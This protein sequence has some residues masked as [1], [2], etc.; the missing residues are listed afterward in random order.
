[1]APNCISV[2]VVEGNR[3][4]R[5]TLGE[6]LNSQSDM[7]CGRAL[8]NCERALEAIDAGEVPD[9]VL[10]DLGL[11]GMSGIEGIRRVHG[12][13]PTSRVL[14]LTIQEDDLAVFDAIAAGA[15]GYLLKPLP[16]PELLDAVRGVVAGAAPINPFIARK[17]LDAFALAPRRPSG[18]EEHGLTAR[19]RGIL[20]LLVE[21]LTLREIGA[22]L[23]LSYHTI[24][25]HLR[26]IYAKL[27]VRSR[28]AAVSRAL[29]E[30]LL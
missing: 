2:W 30:D 11:P 23:E 27:H 21:G 5:D 10:M 22:Q 8:P 28:S 3:A 13:S 16:P 20:Q 26:N 24:S 14:V 9:V 4:V 6:L 1:M 25:N 18:S 7:R 12:L 19:E 15:S 17:L 29:R